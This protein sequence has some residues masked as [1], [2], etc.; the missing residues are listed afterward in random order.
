M[1]GMKAPFIG[2]NRT[3]FRRRK[4]KLRQSQ[5]TRNIGAPDYRAQPAHAT[6]NKAFRK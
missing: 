4:K 1:I 3:T 5:A 2:Q 6:R